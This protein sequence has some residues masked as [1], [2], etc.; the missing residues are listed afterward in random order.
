MEQRGASGGRARRLDNAMARDEEGPG[1]TAAAAAKVGMGSAARSGDALRCDSGRWTDS[2]QQGAKC[3][4]FTTMRT[5]QHGAERFVLWGGGGGGVGVKAVMCK[6]KCR[7]ER[8][9]V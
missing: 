6:V 7:R 8:A 9:S 2:G 4:D 1:L 3:V 5:A